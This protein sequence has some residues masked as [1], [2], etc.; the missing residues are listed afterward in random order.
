MKNLKIN[1]AEKISGTIKIPADKSISHRAAMLASV[2]SGTSVIENFLLSA[3]CKSTLSSVA[4]FGAK[5]KKNDARITITGSPFA[6]PKKN[7][8]CGNSGT[9]VRL[10]SGLAAGQ[11][12]H[13]I[14][15]GDNSLSKRPMKRVTEPL[16]LMGA[17]IQGKNGRLPL[18]LRAAKLR[19]I[20]Y[21]MPVP[22]AQVKSALL[23]GALGA[24]GEIKIIEKIISRDHTERML[25]L[26][27]VKLTSHGGKIKM[28]CGQKLKACK[29]KVPG[30]IS[31]AAFFICAAVLLKSSV[32][33]KDV[34][35]NPTRTG[36]LRAL[37]KMGVKYNLSKKRFFGREP[38]SDIT[39]MKSSLRGAV[40]SKKD[41]PS[42]I[43]EVP[44]LALCATQATG[45]TV[46]MGAEELAVKE[47]DRLE[48]TYSQLLKMGADIKKRP[49]G[50]IIR[51][52]VKLKGTSLSGFGDHRIIMMLTLA[53]LGAA[54]VS[55]ID[56]T[57]GVE[58]SFPDFFK[59]LEKHIVVKAKIPS[60]GAPS[61]IKK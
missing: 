18:H 28:E 43:D 36:F 52:P 60:R 3:D 8:D 9:T 27:G 33:M 51:G 48:A 34:G 59:E 24:K 6:S 32:K 41:I 47:C 39:I 19:G 54:G 55:V 58:I 35:I 23:L 42:M 31:S 44:L 29:I 15:T 56:N 45:K 11:G 26:F 46:I 22:S 2:A 7:V 5:V 21:T 57:K 20:N 14:F 40:F 1:P 37:E 10:L 38:V 49:D 25:P 61:L 16:K 12:V 17:K 4:A 30:D 50:F 53:A 13:A